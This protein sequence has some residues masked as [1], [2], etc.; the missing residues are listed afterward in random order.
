M[1]LNHV[2]AFVRVVQDGSFTAAAK[3]LGLPKS[4]VS[5]SVAQ[6]EQ[7]LGV[8]LLHRTT[9]KLHLTDAGTA[10]HDRVARALADIDEAQSAASD[11]QRELRGVVRIT[12]PVD[13]GVWAVAGIAARFV[14]KHPTVHVEVRLGSRVVDLVAEGF[15]LAVRAGK[16]RDQSLIARRVGSLELGLYASAKY[17]ARRGAPASLADLAQHDCVLLQ[18]DSGPMTW[19]LVGPDGDEHAVE[20]RGSISADDISFMKKAVLAAGGIALLPLFLCAREEASGKLV[21][22]LPDYRLGG[23]DLHVVYPSVRYV[24]QRVVAFRDYLVRELSALSRRC[25]EAEK[26]DRALRSS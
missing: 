8:R 5:R 12:A 1:D 7:D 20:P 26:A 16:L 23:S 15:D 11:L 22:V 4:S 13:L 3:A 21:R 18:T 10:F 6:L 24:P 9:R 17:L 14:K 25:Y 2:T 19:K